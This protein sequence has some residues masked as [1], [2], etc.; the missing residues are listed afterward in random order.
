V[1]ALFAVAASVNGKDTYDSALALSRAFFRQIIAE[2]EWMAQSGGVYAVTS[3]DAPALSSPAA[4]DQELTT[5]EGLRLARLTPAHVLRQIAELAARLEGVHVHLTSNRPIRPANAAD[6]WESAALAAFER[7]RPEVFDLTGGPGSKRFRYMAPLRVESSCLACH[8]TQGYK[9]GDV[10]GGVSVSFPARPFLAADTRILTVAG[11]VYGF[12]W[13]LGLAG[14]A[15]S[16]G[17][18]FQ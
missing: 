13:M 3:A 6:P 2:R 12:I 16:S 18:I 4:P 11:V 5:V 14:L 9:V 7:G 1:L 17:R 15:V 8:A 10:R